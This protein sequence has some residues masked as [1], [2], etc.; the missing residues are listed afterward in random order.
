M[1]PDP[2]DAMRP[3]SLRSDLIGPSAPHAG[4]VPSPRYLQR[5]WNVL[6]HVDKLPR[7]SLLEVGSGAGMLLHELTRAGFR[8][9][10]LESSAPARELISRLAEESGVKIR[11]ES[12]PDA[13]W[14]ESFDVVV[15]MEVLEHIE[16]DV[17]ALS[18]WRQWL[19]PGGSLVLSVPAH[20]RRWG[21]ADV[22]AGHYRRY[23]KESLRQLL[24]QSGFLLKS[25]QSYGFPVANLLERVS[26][27]YYRKNVRLDTEGNPDREANN[28]RSGIDRAHQSL[29]FRLLRSWPGRVGLRLSY[30]IQDRFL[31]TD[32]GNGYIAVAQR[33]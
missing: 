13:G 30:W 8:C 22:W 10:A 16:N 4:W 2:H 9:T 21:P 20:M 11:V 31:G 32:L 27:R 33:R 26:Q 24:E 25:V 29:G 18:Q 3:R 15:A 7:G 12:T 28:A 23:E 17:A 19:R 5:R 1:N 14:T 6:S